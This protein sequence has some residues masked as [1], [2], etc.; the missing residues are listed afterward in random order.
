MGYYADCYVLTNNRT[1]IFIKDFLGTFAPNRMQQAEFYEVPQYGNE[2][3]E[4][5]TLA[6]ELIHYLESNVTTPH[7]ICW[8]NLEDNKIRLVNCFFTND[9]N[10]IVGLSCHAD[11]K[12]EN[13][14][15][16]RLMKHCKSKVGYIT[17]EQPPP[18]NSVKFIENI[19]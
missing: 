6:D 14:L 4:E 12:T 17:Y 13:E 8:E 15:L 1:K 9:N 3:C 19:G 2:I 7:S 18:L 5:F 10:L 16:V 11:D